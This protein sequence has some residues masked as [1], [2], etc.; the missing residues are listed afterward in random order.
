[1]IRCK[2]CKFWR[3]DRT[4]RSQDGEVLT[5]VGHCKH[6]EINDYIEHIET[7]FDWLF[8]DDFGCVLGEA[9]EQA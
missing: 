1:M 5:N 7:W 6:P 3:I 2:Q 4:Y 9:A 8:R